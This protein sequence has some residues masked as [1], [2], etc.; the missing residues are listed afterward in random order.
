MPLNAMKYYPGLILNLRQSAKTQ[1]LVWQMLKILSNR[2][3]A[4]VLKQGLGTVC[5]PDGAEPHRRNCSA[6]HLHSLGHLVSPCFEPYSIYFSPPITT[7]KGWAFTW[8]SRPMESRERSEG[9]GFEDANSD[10]NS[11]PIRT[12]LN[13]RS[14]AHGQV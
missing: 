1:K 7:Q 13:T 11:Q 14:K 4:A 8:P 12:P 5:L 9:R 6:T 3:R 2:Y 10:Q